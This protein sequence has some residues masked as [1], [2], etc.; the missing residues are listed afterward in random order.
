MLDEKKY[1]ELFGYVKHPFTGVDYVEYYGE[2]F[3]A[4]GCEVEFV[5]ANDVRAILPY[6]DVY[7]RQ[8][9]DNTKVYLDEH[10][11][12]F[13]EIEKLVR[14]NADKLYT[15]KKGEVLKRPANLDDA[16]AKAAPAAAAPADDK[17]EVKPAA[18]RA[19]KADIDIMVEDDDA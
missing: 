9:R 19:G 3:R 15:L 6:T 10:P 18:K 16:P 8:G 7:K 11:E 5:F 13:A 12:L 1:R 14:D 4:E 17:I 2:L